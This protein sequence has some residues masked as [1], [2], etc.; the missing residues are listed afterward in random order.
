[1]YKYIYIQ[2]QIRLPIGGW[3]KHHVRSDHGVGARFAR[4]KKY[5]NYV[6][7]SISVLYI[8]IYIYYIYVCIYICVCIYNLYIY[9]CV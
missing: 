2:I 5:G 9:M 3:A 4:L 6:C 8:Y 1:M 7:A